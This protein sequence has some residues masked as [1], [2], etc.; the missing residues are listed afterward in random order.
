M[1]GRT[2]RNVTGDSTQRI[3][4]VDA[5]GETV[6]VAYR[7]ITGTVATA[8]VPSRIVVGSTE[9]ADPAGFLGR[10]L[11]TVAGEDTDPAELVAT[12]LRR[13]ADA[14]GCVDL[15]DVGSLVLVHPEGWTRTATEA[16]HRAGELVGVPAA[17]VHLSAVPSEAP[18][19]AVVDMVTGARDPEGDGRPDTGGRDRSWWVRTMT[20]AVVA[21]VLV[22]A[23]AV[24]LT[25]LGGFGDGTVPEEPT[26]ERL[27][28]FIGDRGTLDCRNLYTSVAA[29]TVMDAG[30]RPSLGKDRNVGTVADDGTSNCTT[31]YVGDQ[32]RAREIPVEHAGHEPTVTSGAVMLGFRTALDDD[33]DFGAPADR[34]ESTDYRNWTLS[35]RLSTDPDG[36]TTPV[37]AASTTVPG[38]GTMALFVLLG[39]DAS[40]SPV[41]DEPTEPDDALRQIIDGFEGTNLPV[42]TGRAEGAS[43]G[44]DLFRD[45]SGHYDCSLFYDRISVTGLADLGIRVPSAGDSVLRESG[46][47]GNYA[48]GER[49]DEGRRLCAVESVEK[50][51][52][53][54]ITSGV[55]DGLPGNPVVGA[56]DLDGWEEYWAF[57]PVISSVSA[58]EDGYQSYNLR[59]CRSSED[60]LV[61]SVFSDV[62]WDDGR[63][64]AASS[65]REPALVTARA[66][67]GAGPA[68]DGAAT[69]S[70]EQ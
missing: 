4:A 50:V 22:I 31:V 7:D 52:A 66:L 40:F 69:E 61:F 26:A 45:A 11:V 21:A 27:E 53:V 32:L 43:H 29:R 35:T 30:L 38:H 14:A 28:A 9:L 55:S 1:T 16:L 39:D 46:Y 60:C 25:R 5:V 48:I 67:V 15:P 51:A 65:A 2:D 36:G 41:T 59:R 68:G 17:R 20:A 63:G 70:P 42:V 57:E 33:H 37:R 34:E 47:Y 54:Q 44:D 24:L 6:Q 10:P 23:G 13:A 58:T 12:V 3:L 64:N 62:M 56:D 8:T 19:R 18:D 49:D